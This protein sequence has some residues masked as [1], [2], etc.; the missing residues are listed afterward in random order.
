MQEKSLFKKI[1]YLFICVGI[2]LILFGGFQYVHRAPLETRIVDESAH[3]TQVQ[4]ILNGKEI[5]VE[6]LTTIA[7]YHHVTAGIFVVFDKIFDFESPK[8]YHVRM[9]AVLY[10]ATLF[11]LTVILLVT[12]RMPHQKVLAIMT[13]PVLAPYLFIGYTETFSLLVVIG[14]IILYFQKQYVLSSIVMFG[15][16]FV[17]QDNI[18]WIVA[19]ILWSGVSYLAQSNVSNFPLRKFVRESVGYIMSI[20]LFVLFVLINGGVA[21][22]DRSRHPV[23]LSA[24]NIF[25]FLILLALIF[26]PTIISYRR[27]ICEVVQRKIYLSA[28]IALG[29]SSAYLLGF[30][31]THSYN[32]NSRFLHNYLGKFFSENT[33]GIAPGI[34]LMLISLAFLAA[35]IRGMKEYKAHLLVVYGVG[36]LSLALHP[37]MEHRYYIIPMVLL[38]IFV[39]FK[40]RRW[41]YVQLAYMTALSATYYWIVFIK[42]WF[43]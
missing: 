34:I 22:G 37:L 15:S 35:I 12:L 28:C 16:L 38:I 32:N 4:R 10:A 3:V 26:L 8:T 40:N 5:R 39:T 2:F 6:R 20:V 13:L 14:G 31:L 7:G 29:A 24:E 43:K 27:E 30:E 9:I 21:V 36:L 25:F 17:R 1:P 23:S 41:F 11:V 42:D 33:F 18:M 19:L